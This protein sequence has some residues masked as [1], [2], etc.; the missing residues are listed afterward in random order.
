MES[1]DMDLFVC[2]KSWASVFERGHKDG[3]PFELAFP[4][5]PHV[6]TLS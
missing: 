2:P 3:N 5:C 6:L 1:K 4:V